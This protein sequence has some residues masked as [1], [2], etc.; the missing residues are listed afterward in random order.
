MF[1]ALQRTPTSAPVDEAKTPY[2]VASS[3][4]EE[5]GG[6]WKKAAALMHERVEADRKL[7]NELVEPLL[8]DAVWQQIRNAAHAERKAFRATGGNS[9]PDSADGI[10]QSARRSWMEYPIWGGMKL[11]DATGHDL[12]HA[13]SQYDVLAKANATE[14]DRMRRVRAA[15]ERDDQPVRQQLDEQ[16]V[17]ECMAA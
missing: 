13:A 8:K 16:A 10:R 4:L 15:L 3:C 6:D 5:A 2:S 7:F 12:D 1:Q 14:R 17:A 11:G 9:T